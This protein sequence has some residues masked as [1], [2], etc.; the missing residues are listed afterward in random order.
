MQLLVSVALTPND[1]SALVVTG[2]AETAALVWSQNYHEL[3]LAALATQHW[4]PSFS[5][6]AE[7]RQRQQVDTALVSPLATTLATWLAVHCPEVGLA[8]VQQWAFTL[9][10]IYIYIWGTSRQI[11]GQT[12]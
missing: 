10:N 11:S 9:R 1:T 2:C 8:D 4:V 5:P 6:A 7:Q 3:E 12:A